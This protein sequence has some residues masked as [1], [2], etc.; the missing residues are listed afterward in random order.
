MIER[1]QSPSVARNREPI[2]EELRRL[3]PDRARVLELA[4]GTGEHAVWFAAALPKVTWQPSDPDATARSSIAAWSAEAGLANVL[5]PLDIDASAPM[6]PVVGRFDALVCINMIHITPWEA[7]L[8][9]MAGAGR[10]L[11]SDGQLITYGAYKREGRHTSATNEAFEQWLKERDP[12]FC[13]RDVVE[14]EA[15]AAAEGLALRE[16]IAMPANNL[17]LVFRNLHRSVA[18]ED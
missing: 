8:G 3:L 12:R 11:S 5:A 6:W 14:V 9:L 1:Q 17:M 7:T 15:A 16:I 13:V 4:S 10:V 2:L 18:V